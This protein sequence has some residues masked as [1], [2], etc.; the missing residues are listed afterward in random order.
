MRLQKRTGNLI[1]FVK[2]WDD[3][4]KIQHAYAPYTIHAIIYHMFC[5]AFLSSNLLVCGDQQLDNKL[6][7]LKVGIPIELI[8]KVEKDKCLYSS[9]YLCIYFS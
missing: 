9:V 4:G 3:T 8:G 2:L 1:F 6:L 5:F 7:F